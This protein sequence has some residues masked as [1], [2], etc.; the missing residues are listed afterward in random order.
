MKNKLFLLVFLSQFTLFA[1]NSTDEKPFI[2]IIKGNIENLPDGKMTLTEFGKEAF[3]ATTETKNGRFELK[4]DANKYPEP[5][6]RGVELVHFDEKNIKR[7]I[8]Y[9]TTKNPN[10]EKRYTN[11]FMLENGVE[12]N[13]ALEEYQLASMQLPDSI[14]LMRLTSNLTNA[15]Q[16]DIFVSFHLPLTKGYKLFD[17]I[18]KKYPYSYHL[19]YQ[20]DHRKHRYTD[21]ENTKIFNHFD[22]NVQESPTGLRLKNYFK[23]RPKYALNPALMLVSADGSRKPIISNSVRLNMVILWASWCPPCIEEIPL[24]KEIYAKYSHLMGFRMVSVS[25]DRKVTAWKNALERENMPWE[26][27][28]MS[29][30]L[31]EYSKDWFPYEGKIPTVVFTDN[32]GK[33]MESFIGYH[34]TN[35]EIYEKIIEKVNR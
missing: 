7:R 30:E 10:D 19:L 4:L 24:L 3:L 27:L 18:V 29:E 35:R 11:F 12:F 17:D 5:Q 32:D 13:G 31:S 23:N 2:I 21:E 33:I 14:K 22:K 16:T 6:E 34:Q 1:Q 9:L 8:S 20:L 26:Q 15:K 28:M 25:V